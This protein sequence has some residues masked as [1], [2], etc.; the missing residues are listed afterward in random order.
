[1]LD[2][3]HILQRQR[4]RVVLDL[5]RYCRKVCCCK[6]LISPPHQRDKQQRGKAEQN[7]TDARNRKGKRTRRDF[8][9]QTSTSKTCQLKASHL[10]LVGSR[11]MISSVKP[12]CWTRFLSSTA[13]RLSSLNFAA[14]MDASHI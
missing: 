5:R 4:G 10:F 7:Q 11:G 13:T 9:L 3:L 8:H 12:S 14:A 6:R 1:M 2:P